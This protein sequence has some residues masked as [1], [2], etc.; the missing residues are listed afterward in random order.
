MGTYIVGRIIFILPVVLFVSIM[1]F[2]SIHFIPGDVVDAMLGLQADEAAKEN[3]RQELGLDKPIIAQYGIWLSKVLRGD[4]G[5]SIITGHPVLQ[6]I[7]EKLPA[8]LLLSS[9]SL[10]ITVLIAI[11]MG[12]LAAA[13]RNSIW[14]VFAL[15]NSLF[16]T[17]LPGFWLGI[18]VILIFGVHLGWLPTMG[19]ERFSEKP[20]KCLQHLILPAITLSAGMLG[21]VT[22]MTRSQMLE[23]LSKD[24]VRTAHAKGLTEKKVVLKHVLTNALSPTI[25]VLGLQFGWTLGSA[26]VVEEVFVWPGIGRLVIGAIHSRDYPILQGVVLIVAL[27]FVFVNLLV[28]ISYAFLDPRIR[29]G[30]K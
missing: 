8:T 10:L 9:T 14:D 17:S 19:Y 26:M 21:A 6:L 23:E 25:T 22:R 5:K 12:I 16:A 3:L 18:M 11:P 24:Y 28:D 13:K 15:G 20:I 30:N 1:V 29:Y 2:F 27:L 7:K 4:L